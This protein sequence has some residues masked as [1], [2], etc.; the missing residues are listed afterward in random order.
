MFSGSQ[1]ALN[2]CR[3]VT[4]ASDRSGVMR[5]RACSVQHVQHVEKCAERAGKREL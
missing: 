3:D 1:L 2:S 4:V 5:S